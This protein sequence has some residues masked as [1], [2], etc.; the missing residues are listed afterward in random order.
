MSAGDIEF[1]GT[2]LAHADHPQ[3]HGLALGAHRGAMAGIEFLAGVLAGAVQRQLGQLR[4]CGGDVGQGGLC[5]TVE[6]DQALHD[7]LAQHP[8]GRARVVAARQQGVADRVHRGPAGSPGGQQGQ[9]AGVAPVQALQETRVPGQR[10][11]VHEGVVTGHGHVSGPG[12]DRRGGLLQA[13]GH[14]LLQPQGHWF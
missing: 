2:E 7:Q 13:R 11:A 1:V 10:L 12:K 14:W 4:D 8:Q 5:I 9:I 3:L 6:L